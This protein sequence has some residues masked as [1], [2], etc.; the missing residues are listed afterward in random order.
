[1]ERVRV[2]RVATHIIPQRIEVAA[3]NGETNEESA[4]QAELDGLVARSWSHSGHL[5]TRVAVYDPHTEVIDDDGDKNEYPKR[6]PHYGTIQFTNGEIGGRKVHFKQG[7]RFH[8]TGRLLT[9]IHS[10]TLRAFLLRAHA[11]EL[12]EDEKADFADL[13]TT[14]AQT[15]LVAHSLIQFTG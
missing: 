1:M 4:V 15:Y 11:V 2:K 8:V 7:D 10:E 14:Y 6:K 9:R 3:A 13:R 12:L 5:F